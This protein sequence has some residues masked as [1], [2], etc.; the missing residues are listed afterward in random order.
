MSLFGLVLQ[1][2]GDIETLIPWTLCDIM[3]HIDGE[4]DRTGL[5]CVL[6]DICGNWYR[7]GA[8]NTES[9]LCHTAPSTCLP[10]WYKYINTKVSNKKESLFNLKKYACNFFV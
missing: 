1:F 5:S 6:S 10:F 8:F 2:K 7:V 3:E 4:S 9:H